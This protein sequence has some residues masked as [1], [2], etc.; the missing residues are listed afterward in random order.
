MNPLLFVGI[1]YLAVT[2]AV[3]GSIV[4]FRTDRFSYSSHSSQFLENGALFWG[5]NAWHYGILSVL[6]AHVAAFAAPGWWSRLLGGTVRLY[7]L[8]ITGYGLAFLAGLGLL[9]LIA[10]RLA[11]RRVFRV[12]STGD[13]LLLAILLVQV[14]TGLYVALAYRFGGAW[15]P[16]TAVPWLRSLVTLHPRFDAIA[17]MPWPV[18]L[19]AVGAFALFLV[20]P[21]TR[22]VHVVTYPLG[23]L[24]RPYQLVI[25]NRRRP[26]PALAGVRSASRDGAAVVADTSAEAVPPL[27]SRTT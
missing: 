3:V 11:V 16:H 23:Y 7:V 9:L 15:Y 6:A 18:K 2:V 24:W 27:S 12:T 22:L 26:Q 17:A 8:E 20:F 13:W 25:W 5:S 1:P 19:H 21:Y 14:G 4:R 10:R